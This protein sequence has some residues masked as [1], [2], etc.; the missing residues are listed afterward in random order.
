LAEQLGKVLL[1]CK[2]IYYSP[3]S[4]NRSRKTFDYKVKLAL[5]E[6][7][8]LIPLLKKRIDVSIERALV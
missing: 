3:D 6:I 5:Q 8:I 4:F 1:A 2:K 7:S